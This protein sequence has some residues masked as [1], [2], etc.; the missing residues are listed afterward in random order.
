M[1]TAR[2]IARRYLVEEY[3]T[4][5]PDFLSM[6]EW[7]DE[8]PDIVQDDGDDVDIHDEV[9][10]LLDVVAQRLDDEEN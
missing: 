10:A 5:E 3:L 8:Q 9:L 6:V 4:T 1:S 7:L 2:E